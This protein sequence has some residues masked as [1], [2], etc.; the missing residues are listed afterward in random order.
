MIM[1]F[2]DLES[3]VLIVSCIINT[4]I[5]SIHQFINEKEETNY[6]DFYQVSLVFKYIFLVK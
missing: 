4:M 3:C 6:K 5:T 1:F 2:N